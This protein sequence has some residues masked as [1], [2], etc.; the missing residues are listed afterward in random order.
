MTLLLT[1]KCKLCSQVEVM[2]CAVS[3]LMTVVT[4]KLSEL[5]HIACGVGHTNSVHYCHLDR[6]LH[7]QQQWRWHTN[8]LLH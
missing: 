5:P 2:I 1:L 8:L 6:F 4:E 3:V 7:Q